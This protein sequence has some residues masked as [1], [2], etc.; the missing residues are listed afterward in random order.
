MGSGDIVVGKNLPPQKPVSVSPE[1]SAEHTGD[2]ISGHEKQ[3]CGAM[4]QQRANN[5]AVS[6]PQKFLHLVGYRDPKTR[7][8]DRR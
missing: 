5:G 7:P 2:P 1:T 8:S 4:T 3:N 6:T